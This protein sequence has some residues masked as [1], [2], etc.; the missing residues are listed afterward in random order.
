MFFV[1]FLMAPESPK[2]PNSKIYGYSIFKF[3][4]P[5]VLK[6]EGSSFGIRP[7]MYVLWECFKET[8]Q[9]RAIT[10]ILGAKALLS[11]FPPPI[12]L[13]TKEGIRKLYFDNKNWKN[14]KAHIPVKFWIL[15][16]SLKKQILNI[17]FLI[18][19]IDIWLNRLTLSGMGCQNR[20]GGA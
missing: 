16:T 19:T 1:L 5:R 3:Q 15:R 10:V 17:A 14:N 2:C 6:R 4:E 12:F 9:Q 8:T 20:Y 11:P 18:H 7:S 13:G